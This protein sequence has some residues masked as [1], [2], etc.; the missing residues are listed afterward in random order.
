ML[1]VSTQKGGT[2]LFD[3]RR[4]TARGSWLN[5]NETILSLAFT[6]DGGTLIAGDGVGDVELFDAATRAPIGTLP[7]DGDTIYEAVASPDG[8]TIATADSGG[9]LRLWDLA[10][11]QQLGLAVPL[12]S[13]IY[14]AS[15]SGGT[16]QRLVT[17]DMGGE[18]VVWPE[19]LFATGLAPFQHDLCPRLSQ[20][21][22]RL[23]WR[24]EVSP[25]Q[26]YRAT[27]PE[28]PR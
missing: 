9:T 3:T 23:Q 15:F 28:L 17:A 8:R 25:D 12:G 6:P 24:D 4:V 14:G 22:S 2:Q 20:N 7:G 27:C 13:V 11:E 19:P 5:T 16:P 21:L 10:T 18:I 26:P 1:A